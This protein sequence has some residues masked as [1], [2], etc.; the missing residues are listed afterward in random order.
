MLVRSWL[1]RDDWCALDLD[2]ARVVVVLGRLVAGNR[3][4]PDHLA[5][6][7]GSLGRQQAV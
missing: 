2:P 3:R 4:R 7:C 6:L 5:D 1:V